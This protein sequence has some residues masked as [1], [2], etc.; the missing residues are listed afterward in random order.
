LLE[1]KETLFDA[2][3]ALMENP[4]LISCLV[5]LLL[6]TWSGLVSAVTLNAAPGTIN[7]VVDPRLELLAVVQYLSGYGERLHL[8]TSF[9]FPYKKEVGDSFS[10][11]KDH[12]A[13]RLFA[14][15]S[16]AGFAFDAPPASMLYLSSPPELTL[17]MP[18]SEY[19]KNRAGGGQRLEEFIAALRDFVRQTHFV[20]FYEAHE[21]FY[22]QVISRAEDSLKGTD[23]IGTLENYY[24]LKQH[25]YTL[26][27]VPLFAG[28][29]GPRIEKEDKT[30]DVY[31]II[32]PWEAKEGWPEFGS[33]E[34]LKRIAWHEF[35]HSF[36]NPI[37]E[38]NSEEID[39]YS[40]LYAPIAGWMK[41]QAYG[42]W[43]TCVNEHIIRA[44]NARLAYLEESRTAGQGAAEQVLQGEI[45]R[46]KSRGFFYVEALSQRLEQYEANREKFPTFADF[47]PELISVFRELSK[48]KLGEDFFS[49]PFAGTI[50]GVSA[51]RKAVVLIVPTKEADK[52][53]QNKI[54]AYVK[55]IRD[56]FFMDSSILTDKQALN[57]DLSR[58][59]VVAYGT[60]KGNLWLAK[61]IDKLP[62]KIEPDRVEADA[63]FSGDHLRFITAWPN[64]QN[65]KR[66][67]L[68]YTAQ[69]AED[70]LGINN[71]FHGPT[72]Y[73]VAIG[74]EVLKAANYLKRN[75]RWSLN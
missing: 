17:Q 21:S 41:P 45:Q 47:Y 27:L 62:V 63:V 57:S 35:S 9:D 8:I 64:P 51:D 38:K 54:Q 4:K 22:R 28:G 48:A 74:T 71:V 3:G 26:I 24:G 67:V 6:L 25:S 7:V 53:V 42:S 36:V 40:S 13:V 15:M 34:S 59:S 69:Q 14:E 12:A 16:E 20:D 58:N 65:P 32:G 5:A 73:V 70:I 61:L 19:L 37:T 1:T 11:Y 72:D 43:P 60:I 2:A 66:G 52:T 18:F 29:Y 50:N 33:V 55:G 49:V 56:M 68:I 31:E 46:E 75:G 23:Y 10:Q 39:K 30:F 44:V